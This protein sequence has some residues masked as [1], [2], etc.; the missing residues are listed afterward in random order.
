VSDSAIAAS[1]EQMLATHGPL[2]LDQLACLTDLSGVEFA[3]FEHFF[4]ERPDSYACGG[5][6]T[7][8]FAGRTRPVR[9]DYESMGQALLRAFAEFPNGAAVEDLHWFP[10]LS[11]VG[12]T[13]AI[14]RRRVSRELS[15]RTDLFAHISRAKYLPIRI[16]D[17]HPPA[18]KVAWVGVPAFPRVEWEIPPVLVPPQDPHPRIAHDDEEFNP[19]AFYTGEFHFPCE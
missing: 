13:K 9:V 14:T 4:N 6:G 11:T 16:R 15:R 5:D 8:W 12:G 7:W 17:V 2:S 1:V 19:F 18:V 10:C 3:V